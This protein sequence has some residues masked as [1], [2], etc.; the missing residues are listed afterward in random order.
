MYTPRLVSLALLCLLAVLCLNSGG[1]ASDLTSGLIAY[2]PFNGNAND[3]SGNGN[4]GI[5]HGAAL[6][7]DRCGNPDSAF[8][9]NR[10]NADWIEVPHNAV[11]NTPVNAGL[12]L[13]LWIHPNDANPVQALISK[14]PLGS[15]ALFHSP[16]TS[17]HAGLFD[18]YL[19][20]GQPVFTSQFTDGCGSEG[21]ISQIPPLAVQ[22]WQHLVITVDVTNPLQALARFYIDGQLGDTQVYG[23]FGAPI[24]S[25]PSSEPIRIGARKDS[26]FADSGPAYFLG[27]LDDIRIYNRPLTGTEVVALHQA[28]QCL[29]PTDSEGP[30]T[31]NVIAAP[32]PVAVNTTMTITA[33]ADDTTTGGS[34]IA[35]AEYSLNGGSPVPMN[36][37]DGAFDAVSEDVEATIP[38]FTEA[39]V[40]E[41]CVVGTDAAS[42]IGP[43]EC[44]LLAVFD[45]TA[46][47]VT[48]GG[49]IQSPEG[50]YT[51]NPLL[52]GKA[53]F[54]FVSKY[55]KGAR[56]PTGVTE[57]QFKVANLNFHLD[58]YEWLVV[59]GARAQFKGTG[60]INTSGNYGFMLTAIDGQIPGGGGVD[61]FRIKIWDKTTDVIVYDNKFGA[62]D[63]GNDATELGG[64]SIVIHK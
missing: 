58:T 63:T 41:V 57:F 24:L 15:C 51:P 32:N 38:A 4:H 50:A 11:Q 40:H 18:V 36:A 47:F 25:Q 39:G 23:Q 22:A 19:V 43:A 17:N 49:W 37:Q 62:S 29:T 13:S 52:I 27:A 8:F 61:K 28:E 35:T 3:T 54:G 6:V 20:A 64:G 30:V 34:T 1:A 33:T 10:A 12:T 42:N 55:Q 48:G 46:G 44:I 45:P 5:V 53:N 21:H 31:S 2:Y 9:F 14:Q 26:V 59:A 56:V 60:T 7:A 16:T